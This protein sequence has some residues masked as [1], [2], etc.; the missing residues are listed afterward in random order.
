[1]DRLLQVFQKAA[2]EISNQ[3]PQS[4][5][6][7]VSLSLPT[8]GTKGGKGIRA[9]PTPIAGSS[10]R[11]NPWESVRGMACGAAKWNFG[12]T[13][14]S[15]PLLMHSGAAQVLQNLLVGRPVGMGLA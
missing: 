6:P 12:L 9:P 15:L 4:L 8:Q 13:F 7:A 14:Y 3:A 10:Q 1:M 2:W 11:P 5:Q